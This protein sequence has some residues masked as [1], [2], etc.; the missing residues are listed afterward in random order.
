MIT[1]MRHRH[2]ITPVLCKLH[3]PSVR[4]HV[5]FKVA[6]LIRQSL[7]G[8]DPLYLADDCSLV[9]D[10][11]QHSSFSYFFISTFSPGHS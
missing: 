3:W 6:C 9:S 10:S 1:D 4:K 2:H 11:T 5:K 8:Q 7:S